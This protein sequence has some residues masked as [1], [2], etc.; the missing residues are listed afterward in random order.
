MDM[1]PVNA[2]QLVQEVDGLH[3]LLSGIQG[4]LEEEKLVDAI[5]QALSKRG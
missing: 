2:W 3:V 5:Q 1:L 4:T